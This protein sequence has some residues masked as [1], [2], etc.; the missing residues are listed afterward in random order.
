MPA[1]A[2]CWC[3][4]TT[5]WSMRTRY[6]SGAYSCMLPFVLRAAHR[7]PSHTSPPLNHFAHHPY[8]VTFGSWKPSIFP[9][10]S[11]SSKSV[12][13]VSTRL[14][15]YTV[16]I[17]LFEYLAVLGGGLLTLVAIHSVRRH[18]IH[19]CIVLN[20]SFL[21]R[22][23]QWSAWASVFFIFLHQFWSLIR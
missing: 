3:P 18:K 11:A 19:I 20:I 7:L 23:Q 12:W 5:T 2:R 10:T 14:L 15:C 1:V 6:G 22:L 13:I 9:S 17:Q 21:R 4:G 16:A 8:S